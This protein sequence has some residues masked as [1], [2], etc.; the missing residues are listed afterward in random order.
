MSSTAQEA[1]VRAPSTAGRRRRRYNNAVGYVFIAPWLIGFFGFTLIPILASLVLAF[2][3][4]DILTSP[5]WIG[6]DNFERMLFSDQRYWNSLEATFYYAFTSVPLRLVFALALA[7]VLNAGRSLVGVYRAIYYVPSIVGGSVAVAV[8]WR[9]VFGREGLVNSVLEVVGLQGY[10]W[11]G[12]PSTAIWALIILAVWQFGSP[13]LIFLAGLKQIPNE[14]YEAASIDGAGAV[15]K[16]YLI[17]IPL[18]S[19]VI[20]FNLVMQ[21]ISGFMVFTQAFI[22]TGG[23]PLDTTLFY[24][25]YL[26]QRA[27]QNFD[28]GYAAAMAWVLLLIIAFF[29]AIVFKSSSMWVHYESREE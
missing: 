21:I 1:A 13:M 19:P 16:F 9:Q 8:M 14:F 22:I 24:S 5:R 6:L 12:N 3:D 15:R 29:T 23:G 20:F 4:Y 27:F 26:Y 18:L 28:M 11:L 17:T 2:T 7:M 25:V 10:N